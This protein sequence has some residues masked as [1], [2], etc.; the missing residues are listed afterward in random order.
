MIGSGLRRQRR[1]RCGWRRRGTACRC[2]KRGGA[3]LPV[4]F[5]APTGCCTSSC[6]CRSWGFTAFSASRCWRTSWCSRALASAAA[7]SSTPTCCGAARRVL[8]RSR[9]AGSR[10]G[11]R[12]WRRTTQ[13][14]RMLGATVVPWETAADRVV[15]GV[16][17]RMGAGDTYRQVEVAVDF[18]RVRRV[19]E[20]HGRLPARGEEHARPE[21]PPARRIGGAEIFPEREAVDLVPLADG[22]WEVAAVRPGRR[23]GAVE[24]FRAGDVVVAAGVLGHA[25]PAPRGAAP[26]RLPRLSERLGEGVRTNAQVLVGASARRVGE[27]PLARRRD[28]LGLPAVA[29]DDDRAG[30]LRA[31]LERDGAARHTPAG[32]RRARRARASPRRVARGPRDLLALRPRRWSERTVILLVRCR[33][34]TSACV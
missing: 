26:R 28:R 16:A 29:G 34:A 24:R 4:N 1:A 2:W 33:R 27:D 3:S 19:R 12:S 6:G 21:L 20:L 25:A 10:I 11:A 17:E 31:R 13:P 7:R 30:P 8:G 18:E 9:W 23:R 5:R 14:P 15:R 22:G 32:R